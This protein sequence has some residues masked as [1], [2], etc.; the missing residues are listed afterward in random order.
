M[1]KYFYLLRGNDW[2]KGHSIFVVIYL[3]LIRK[4][5]MF[6][7]IWHTGLCPTGKQGPEKC[8][9][10]SIRAVDIPLF[11]RFLL[12]NYFGIPRY[13]KL[14][15]KKV[16]QFIKSDENY[17]NFAK[18]PLEMPELLKD[19]IE[20][21]LLPSI[22]AIHNLCGGGEYNID[23]YIYLKD[24]ESKPTKKTY[25]IV[26]N[27]TKS[28]EIE[29]KILLPKIPNVGG[30][31]Y[32]TSY[33]LDNELYLE[34]KY[35]KLRV[36]SNSVSNFSTK[37]P[38]EP[39]ILK[40]QFNQINQEVP[41]NYRDI[42]LRLIIP[43]SSTI[44]EDL[45][46]PLF[47]L[48]R[49]GDIVFDK[50]EFNVHHSI[51]GVS[52]RVGS[53]F[54]EIIINDKKFH[55]YSTEESF[56]ILECLDKNDIDSFKIETEQ[57]RLA[58]AF[59][60]GSYYGGEAYYLSSNFNDFKEIEGVWYEK[61]F[62]NMISINEIVNP[63]FFFRSFI[64]KDASYNKKYEKYHKL[65]SSNLFSQL[66]NLMFSE[67]EFQRT[68]KFLVSGSGCEDPIQKGA[69]YSIAIETITNFIS[70]KNIE[71]LKPIKKEPVARELIEEL[72]EIINNY[73]SQLDE[74]GIEILKKKVSNLNTPTNRDKLIKPFEICNIKL[75]QENI[76]SIDRRNAYLHGRSP[77]KTE[78]KFELNKIA[79]E[80][81]FLV[82]CLILKYIGYEGHVINL[83][84]WSIYKNKEK[85]NELLHASALKAER[86]Y[87]QFN[88]SVELNDK[89]KISDSK[90]ELIQFLKD[91]DIQNLIQ[92]I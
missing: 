36:L 19:A 87:K 12:D 86:L 22:R 56:L 59:L 45:K 66:C 79:L 23:L 34:N 39:Q 33:G 51:M 81:H 40:G 42:F 27:E 92:F 71:I 74:S 62:T 14:A 3:I 47:T 6:T 72:L 24:D 63:R 83:P 54:S 76:N 70:Q 85:F 16:K 90:E 28:N 29:F 73:S 8:I 11:P 37:Y 44:E 80:L 41:S 20:K 67:D 32:M 7:T 89:Q 17:L 10:N 5:R 60:C 13:I 84:I 58:F 21:K 9:H 52:F 30:V 43:I 26:C 1:K 50:E 35:N 68:V 46:A 31:L 88:D 64:D 61:E 91:N 82:A 57:I 25:K 48:E 69:M 75:T 77:M 53:G 18:T 78:D 55:F 15:I 65:F 4:I 2:S 49:K 38:Y